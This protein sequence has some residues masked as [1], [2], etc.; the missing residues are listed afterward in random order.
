MKTEMSEARKRANQK[1]DS[2][3]LKRF[4][5]AMRTEDFEAM[6]KHVDVLDESRNHF[7]N[8]AIMSTIKIDADK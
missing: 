4:T 1:W 3:N 7:I 2:V 8:R 5:V 6:E